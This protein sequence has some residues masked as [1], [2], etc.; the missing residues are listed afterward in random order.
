VLRKL[1]NCP[2]VCDE[3]RPSVAQLPACDVGK[4]RVCPALWDT[5]DDED[6]EEDDEDDEDDDDDDD[7]TTWQ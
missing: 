4:R 1:V 6:D 5:D 3:S 2:A 7:D